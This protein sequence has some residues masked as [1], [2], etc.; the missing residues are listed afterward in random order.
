MF[1]AELRR[2]VL[3]VVLILLVSFSSLACISTICSLIGLGPEE[4]PSAATPTVPAEVEATPTTEAP[5]PPR[6]DELILPGIDDPPT[7]DPHITQDATSAEFIVEIFGGL[8]TIDKDLNIIPDLAEDWDVSA[9]GTVYTFHLR[10]DAKFHDG[11]AVTAQD[12][13]YSFERAADPVTES[14]VADTYLGDIVGARDKLS[15]R[16]REVSGV[17]V[18]DDYTLEITIDSPKPYFL[19]K[20]T[21]PTAFVVDKENVERGGRTWTDNPNGTGPF[22]LAE[23]EIGERI[24]LE[25]NDLFYG[26]KP[27]VKRV[28]YTLTGGSAMTRYENGELDAT[29]VTIIDIDRVL[30]PT[31]PLNKEL[32]ITPSFSITY[33]GLN[34]QTPPFDDVK[35]RQAFNMAVDKEIIAEVVL[36]K[37]AEAAYGILPPGFPGYNPDLKGLPFDPD[38]AKELIAESKYG[39]I[40]GLPEITLNI[41]GAGGTAGPVTTAIAEMF[42]DSLG[43][44]VA[45]EQVEFATFL[46]DIN[47]RPNP[48]QMYSIGWIADY[49]D[50]QDFL[51]ILFHSDSLDNRTGYSNPEVDRLLEQARVEYDQEKRFKLYQQAEEIIVQ[52][53]AWI[54]LFFGREYWL[55]KPYVKG[56]IYP[57]M[58]IPRLKYVSIGE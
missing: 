25:R 48:Y 9:D 29:F 53:A 8:V 52:D 37:M 45:I 47:Q 49:P 18:I 17:K 7:L 54:P 36:L 10:R 42:K 33:I 32:T 28:V 16:A 51:D 26:Q 46:S 35:V 14:V 5:P 43:I 30:D 24:V 21:Y 12:F 31:N 27:G 1:D 40:K 50:P 44:E 58:V 34:T 13:K 56:M 15:G 55:T 2:K 11:K 41:S 6:R 4:T 38:R 39:G 22:K 57:P 23:Y 3:S 20:L 19:A